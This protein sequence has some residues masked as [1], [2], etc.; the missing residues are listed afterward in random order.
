LST[1]FTGLPLSPATTMHPEY[2]KSSEMFTKQV[3]I[4]LQN[5]LSS[6]FVNHDRLMSKLSYLNQTKT[7]NIIVSTR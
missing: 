4:D 5:S 3:K 7:I 1:Q 6:K 2:H